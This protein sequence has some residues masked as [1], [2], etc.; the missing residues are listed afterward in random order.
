MTRVVVLKDY[1]LIMEGF[2]NIHFNQ[3]G[4]ASIDE[5]VSRE[6]KI[7]KHW[8]RCFD[9]VEAV[10]RTVDRRFSTLAS[11]GWRLKGSEWW[12]EVQP[13]SRTLY[14]IWLPVD[15]CDADILSACGCGDAEIYCVQRVMDEFRD[16]EL[17]DPMRKSRHEAGTSDKKAGVGKLGDNRAKTRP[18]L[19]NK[20]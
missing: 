13:G 12:G 8:I 7:P 18:L 3:H 10:F 15:G 4:H 17:N 6:A 2:R 9:A 11:V 1:P 14:W 16:G 19:T 5:P 20:D